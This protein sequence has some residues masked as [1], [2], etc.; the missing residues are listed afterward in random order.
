[1]SIKSILLNWVSDLI[2]PLR[3]FRIYANDM[4]GIHNDSLQ[5]FRKL[6]Y[7][8]DPNQALQQNTIISGDFATAILQTSE[9]FLRTEED[10]SL[11]KDALN[12]LDEISGDMEATAGEIEGSVEATAITLE[13]ESILIEITT[14]V[15][16]AAVAEAGA[17]PI[18]D[19][20]GFI[21]TVIVGA[22]V[23][24]DLKNLAEDIYNDVMDLKIDLRTLAQAIYPPTVPEPKH[25]AIRQPKWKQDPNDW[26]RD[27]AHQAE[28]KPLMTTY[29]YLGGNIQDTLIDMLEMGLSPAQIKTIMGNLKA[30]GASDAD[31]IT[32]L[33][34]I[35]SGGDGAYPDSP[36]ASA[37][38]AFFKLASRKGAIY[39]LAQIVT[40]YAAIATI[41]G[42]SRLLERIITSS[43]VKDQNGERS[44]YRGYQFELGWIEQHK[45]QIARVEDVALK[46]DGKNGQ[47][48][49]VIFKSGPFTKGAVVDT[50]SYTWQRYDKE[51]NT[52]VPQTASYVRAR[53]AEFTEQIERDQEK[54]PGY[55]VV[56]VFDA[57]KDRSSLPQAVITELTKLNVTVMTT[58]P[59]KV[60]GVGV[61]PAVPT[62]SSGDGP[63]P[64]PP[65]GPPPQLPPGGPPPQLPS[66]G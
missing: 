6:V 49:D 26:L 50:K 11:L 55:P 1:M 37:I 61:P 45:D 10:L 23:V 25:N 15:D 4:N 5:S 46:D 43:T 18:A 65:G 8:L 30:T 20:A 59:D 62:G 41:P 17:N 35:V 58:P 64:L 16:I 36:K 34:G 21:L 57:G 28:L 48:A 14:D 2:D 52:Y 19:V 39:P 3:D 27:P 66:G 44:S 13:G 38:V 56:Y 47:G 9:D 60:V 31:I 24:N 51:T 12:K 7:Q 54:Y 22:E 32:F 33:N 29:G 40:Q 42:A 63:L 53:I